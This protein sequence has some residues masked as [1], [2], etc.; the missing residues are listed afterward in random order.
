MGPLKVLHCIHSVSW[1]GL[2]IYTAELIQKMANTGIE[3]LVL[4]SEHGRVAEELKKYNIPLITFSEKKLS[5]FAQA[6]LIRKIIKNHNITLLHSHTRLDMWACALAIWDTHKIKHVY[7]LYMNAVPKQDFVHRLLFSKVDGLCSSSET[8]LGE[9]RKNFPIDPAKL[10]LIRYGRAVEQ[11]K[12]CPEKREQLR[13]HYKTEA[14]QVVIGTLCRIDPGKGVKELVEALEHL[15]DDELKKVQLWIIGDPTLSG[16]NQAG[17]PIYETASR[18]LFD[19]IQSR[20]MEERYYQHLIYIP[21]QKDYIPYIDALDI[22]SLASYCETYSLSVLDAMMMAKPV[23]GT[24]AG[25]TPEQVGNQERGLLAEPHSAISLAEAIRF[26]LRHPE[27]IHDQGLKAQEWSKKNH[28]WKE[29]LQAFLKLYSSITL[30]AE[31]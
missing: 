25:G 29:T 15:D 28:D 26:Y 22:F 21:F 19:W 23:I 12:P 24:N 14:G 3:Q 20:R 5:K 27:A 10:H 8:I 2:E 9:V 17:E 16:K 31:K 4:C 1:G 18:D 13:Q 6:R 7:N 30:T 11:F